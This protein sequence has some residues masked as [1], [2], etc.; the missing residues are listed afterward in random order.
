M[1]DDFVKGKCCSEN[2]LCDLCNFM[3]FL[4][5]HSY[6]SV[7]RMENFI[8]LFIYLLVY[9]VLIDAFSRLY[10]IAPNYGVISEQSF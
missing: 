9:C 1:S 4:K 6:Y 2:Y 8:Y 3:Y 5:H 7:E 10:Y